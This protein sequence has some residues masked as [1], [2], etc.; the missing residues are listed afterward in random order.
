MRL[1]SRMRRAQYKFNNVFFLF[2]TRIRP[3][4][5]VTVSLRRLRGLPMDLLSFGR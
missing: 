2:L 3:Q 5:P 4:W 1:A